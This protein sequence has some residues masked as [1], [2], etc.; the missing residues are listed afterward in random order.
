MGKADASKHA[1]Q[2]IHVQ[3]WAPNLTSFFF[4]RQTDGQASF[5]KESGEWDGGVVVEHLANMSSS[6]EVALEL[7]WVDLSYF[8]FWHYYFVLNHVW[9]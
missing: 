1:Y 6:N 9:P 3:L 2:S 4:D 7:L 5:L 8:G